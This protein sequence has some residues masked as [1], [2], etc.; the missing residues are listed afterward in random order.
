[1]VPNTQTVVAAGVALVGIVSIGITKLR[2]ESQLG[3]VQLISSRAKILIG[4][5]MLFFAAIIFISQFAAQNNA[6]SRFGENPAYQIAADCHDRSDTLALFTDGMR[7]THNFVSKE[8]LRNSR[9]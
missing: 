1:M 3:Q 6:N 7:S 2:K 4:L 8:N 9:S 5:I